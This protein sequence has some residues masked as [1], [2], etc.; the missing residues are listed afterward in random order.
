M[1]RR[2][3]FGVVLAVVVGLF[4]LPGVASADH[5]DAM[6]Q[7]RS[8]VLTATLTGDGQVPAVESVDSGLGR[9]TIDRRKHLVCYEL[10]VTGEEAITAGHIHKGAAGVAGPPVIDFSA[11]GEAFG[12]TSSGCTIDDGGGLLKDMLLRPRQYYINLHSAANP[13]GE[14]RGQLVER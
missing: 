5:N 1:R 12:S 9:I 13:A 11:F 7:T 4:A 14:I 6:G 8:R 3:L 2:F 10:I